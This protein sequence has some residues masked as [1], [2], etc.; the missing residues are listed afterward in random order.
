MSDSGEKDTTSRQKDIF[1]DLVQF[2][3]FIYFCRY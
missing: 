3:L 2:Y 1:V